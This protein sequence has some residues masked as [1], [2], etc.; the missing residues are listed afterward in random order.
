LC[1][2]LLNGRSGP[3]HRTVHRSGRGVEDPGDF[4]GGEP[5]H[6]TK[7]QHRALGARQVLQG[8]NEGQLD[9]LPAQVRRRG[10]G[11]VVRGLVVRPWLQPDR[12]GHR[13]P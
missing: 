6:V 9:A 3:L 12:T 8:G 2:P 7:D 10:V 5:E 1:H 4:G 11:L 13:L